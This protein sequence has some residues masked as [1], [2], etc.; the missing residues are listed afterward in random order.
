M[1]ERKRERPTFAAEGAWIVLKRQ[2]DVLQHLVQFAVVAQGHDLA[3]A[4]EQL[5]AGLPT[6]QPNLVLNTTHHTHQ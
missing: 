5:T 2:T 6:E 4:L 3:E 1:R